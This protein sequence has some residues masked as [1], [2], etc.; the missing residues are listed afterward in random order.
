MIKFPCH[1][2]HHFAVE[3]EQAGGAIQCPQCGRLNDIPT[4]SDLEHIE[5][6]VFKL[7]PP[8]HGGQVH[9]PGPSQV[10]PYDEKPDALEQLR[11]AFGKG[12]T[13]DGGAEIDL[14]PSIDDIRKAG[15]IEIPL[16][17]RDELPPGAPKYDPETGELIKP[18]EV[19]PSPHIDPATIP[20]AHRA[21]SYATVDLGPTLTPASA[22]IMLFQPINVFVMGCILFTHGLML[23]VALILAFGFFLIAPFFILV[24][25][26]LLSHYGIIVDAIGPD[27]HNDLPRPLRNLDWHDDL[28]GPFVRVFGAMLMSYLPA[29]F[30]WRLMVRGDPLRA[31]LAIALALAGTFVFPAVVLTTTTSGSMINVRPDRVMGVIFTCGVKYVLCV[32]LWPVLVATY[33]YGIAAT[34]FLTIRNFL[35]SPPP[36]P[37]YFHPVLSVPGL[38][39]GIYLAHYFCV[40]LGLLYREYHD[41]FPWALQRHIPTKLLD[42]LKSTGEPAD[43]TRGGRRQRRD[44][45]QRM[46]DLNRD[47]RNQRRQPES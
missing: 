45:R 36:T 2:G 39:V 37:W 42:R 34:T 7:D 32:I 18:H 41:A 31:P 38:L 47:P 28:W 15:D 17:L 5:E 21:V 46:M 14:R 35:P 40:Y 8:P 24:F 27:T 13:E 33:L 4:L 29:I 43:N 6:G 44:S 25:A 10:L 3:D 30:A 16:A 23:V 19:T 1:C 9:E 22:L 11:R 26:L 20:M 12:K